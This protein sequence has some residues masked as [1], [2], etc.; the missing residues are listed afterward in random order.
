MTDQPSNEA[1]PQVTTSVNVAAGQPVAILV[2]GPTNGIGTA[3]GVLGIVGMAL[4]LVPFVG[5]ILCLL[6]AILGGVGISKGSKEGLPKGMAITGL[7][8]GL[9]GLAIYLVVT[10]VWAGLAT[11]T[12]DPTF[13]TIP[14]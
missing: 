7:V 13:T 4:I 12:V 10:M 14:G 9:V 1:S 2:K 3:G 5:G 11:A 6:G 8:L